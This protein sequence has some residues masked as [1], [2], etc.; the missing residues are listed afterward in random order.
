MIH[1][2]H[3]KRSARGLIYLICG[4][5]LT[6]IAAAQ[7]FQQNVLT[8]DASSA[9]GIAAGDLDGDGDLDA[10]STSY[11]SGTAIWLETLANGPGTPHAIDIAYGRLRGIGAG[12]LDSD[13]DVDLAIA[14]YDEGRFVWLE[15]RRGQG[16]DTFLIHTLRDSVAG[17]WS[18]LVVDID[19][20]RD[21]D[22]VTRVYLSNVVRIF[23]E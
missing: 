8:G 22:L 14:S 15:N 18:T 4:V 23:I 7:G 10:A 5:C 17:P 13:G 16:V 20:G 3:R 6:G 2:T 12:D 1:L 11:S 19:N 9:F 21:A